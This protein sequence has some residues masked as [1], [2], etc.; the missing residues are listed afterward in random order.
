MDWANSELLFI[1]GTGRALYEF[2]NSDVVRSLLN[3]LL[4]SS[5]ST[6]K[7]PKGCENAEARN[8]DVE[9]FGT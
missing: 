4:N 1:T 5:V 9:D 8:E 7:G 3:S 2:S 6:R